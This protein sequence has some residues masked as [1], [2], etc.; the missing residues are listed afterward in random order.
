MKKT[1]ALISLLVLLL[2]IP[3]TSNAMDINWN[4]N[5]LQNS[6][7]DV[8]LIIPSGSWASWKKASTK[9]LSFRFEV[10]N[11]NPSKTVKSYEVSYYPCDE[12]NQQNGPTETV[13]LR[14]DIRA[15]ETATSPEIFI[16]NYNVNNIHYVYVGIS[17]VRYSDG[18]TEYDFSPSYTYWT[19]TYR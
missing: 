12:Y 13:T 1:L 10:K 9:R 5:K 2:S 3:L 14:Q 8:S 16:S 11:T 4:F 7:S 15:Y 19:I 18:S 6:S 17:S